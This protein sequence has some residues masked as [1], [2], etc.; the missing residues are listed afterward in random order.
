MIDVNNKSKGDFEDQSP[1]EGNDLTSR[2]PR[3]MRLRTRAG[4][5]DKLGLFQEIPKGWTN[6]RRD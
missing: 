4:G 1:K 6:V 2:P 5:T 3:V